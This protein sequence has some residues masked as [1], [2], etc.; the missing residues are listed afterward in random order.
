MTHVRLMLDK[1]SCINQ[2][3]MA[4]WEWIWE[5][6]GESA[7]VYQRRFLPSAALWTAASFKSPV[8]PSSAACHRQ[9]QMDKRYQ[10]E[11]SFGLG[12]LRSRACKIFVPHLLICRCVTCS[13]FL[14]AER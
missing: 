13:I 1:I 2:I 9:M 7:L 14:L 5:E 3:G 12:T 8:R 11:F 4:N 10:H 6:S